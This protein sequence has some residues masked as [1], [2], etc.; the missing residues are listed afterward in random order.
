MEREKSASPDVDVEPDIL[1]DI[2][3]D[4]FLNGNLDAALESFNKA[5]EKYQ[6]EFGE[7]Y[8][9]IANVYQSLANVYESQNNYSKAEEC[10]KKSIEINEEY[11]GETNM[12]VIKSTL[13]IIEILFKQGK[14]KYD[15]ATEY[16]K[17]LV[18]SIPTD[19]EDELMDIAEYYES[20]GD[21]LF[22]LEEYPNA[23]ELYEKT[24]EIYLKNLPETSTTIARIYFKIGNLYISS[25][26]WTKG[27]EHLLKSINIYQ[28]GIES[29]RMDEVSDLFLE[30][31]LTYNNSKRHNEAITILQNLLQIYKCRDKEGAK[32]GEIYGMIG[33]IQFIQKNYLKAALNHKMSLNIYIK[34]FGHS[35]LLVLKALGRLNLIS[36]K[37]GLFQESLTY[38]QK[39]L[40][41]GRKIFGDKDLKCLETKDTIGLLEQNSASIEVSDLNDLNLLR[42]WNL[43]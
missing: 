38:F 43:S 15:E 18:K 31:A 10:L 33:D 14:D 9:E 40:S 24:R 25:Q 12:K 7:T 32:V 36:F 2:A 28:K 8:F 34:S 6:F 13:K 30:S 27:L 17:N 16:C 11:Y 22:R 20:I 3:E 21:L 23:V 19:F 37:L 39:M 42:K 41:I 29:E 4:H 5:L 1:V 35:D 26:N